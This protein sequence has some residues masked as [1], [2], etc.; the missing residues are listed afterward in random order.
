LKENRRGAIWQIDT[1]IEEFPIEDYQGYSSRVR[2]RFPLVRTDLNAFTAAEMA[3]LENHGYSLADA[4]I[5][6]WTPWACTRQSVFSWPH[7][8]WA[9]EKATEIALK[10][11]DQR[12]LVRDT[13]RY[14]VGS[15]VE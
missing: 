11:S 3:C 6:S 14:F 12:H 10:D 8:E 15:L 4:A 9:D 7:P 2:S 13:L 1:L 5:R